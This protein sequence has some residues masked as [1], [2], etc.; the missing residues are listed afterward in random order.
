MSAR[1]DMKC[2]N[3]R[4][5]TSLL[6]VLC[7]PALGFNRTKNTSRG[8]SVAPC[9]NFT[10]SSHA[11]PARSSRTSLCFVLRSSLQACACFEPVVVAD[12]GQLSLQT[13]NSYAQIAASAPQG[14]ASLRP[15]L[16]SL[17]FAPHTTPTSELAIM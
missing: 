11:H 3:I 8:R 12:R 5:M 15:V 4:Q 13:P 10:V 6:G 17:I 7:T 1:H 9:R 14:F 2:R 16:K